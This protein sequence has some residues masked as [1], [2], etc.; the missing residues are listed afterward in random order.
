MRRSE[1]E[2]RQSL[3]RIYNINVYYIFS[4]HFDS[5]AQ[6]WLNLGFIPH[7]NYDF[8]VI[9]YNQRILTRVPYVIVELISS[10]VPVENYM[11]IPTPL[12]LLRSKH[13]GFRLR[14]CSVRRRLYFGA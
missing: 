14:I 10:F 2:L 6:I 11:Q 13:A 5:T 8:A 4:K 7:I 3:N 1:L 12:Q 9:E